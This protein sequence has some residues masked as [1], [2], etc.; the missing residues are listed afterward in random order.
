MKISKILKVI[1]SVL[2]FI[3][4]SHSTAQCFTNLSDCLVTT[5]IGKFTY[6]ARNAGL[7]N[8]SGVVGDADH[9]DL[10]HTDSI[11]NGS[12]SNISE[13][14]GLPLEEAEEKSLSVK[15][16]VTQ[17]TGG[18]SDRWL[19]HEIED[20]YRDGDDNDGRLGLLSGARVKIR[21]I[22]GNKIIY[23][24]LGGGNYIWISGQ[25][26][27]EIKYTDSVVSG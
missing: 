1:P 10:D 5:D 4:F 7:G 20:S 25:K 22:N 27:V 13:I 17:H 23:W 24:G 19:L 12:Y 16:E 9:F 11:C 26:V 3:C 21:E 15:V 6:K 2:L 18:D 14:R 8:A